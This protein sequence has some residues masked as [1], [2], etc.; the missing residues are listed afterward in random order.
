MAKF[1]LPLHVALPLYEAFSKARAG[2]VL[3]LQEIGETVQA[4]F[5]ALDQVCS[6]V[7]PWT[8]GKT[9]SGV[10]NLVMA[11]PGWKVS[12]K[13]ASDTGNPETALIDRDQDQTF[14]LDGDHRDAF[15]E[16]RH[17]GMRQLLHTY[18]ALAP[19]HA[20]EFTSPL[21]RTYFARYGVQ[22]D[23]ASEIVVHVYSEQLRHRRFDL[24]SISLHK[25]ESLAISIASCGKVEVPLRV[26]TIRGQ[27]GRYRVVD[28]DLRLSAIRR[29]KMDGVLDDSFTVPV[30][31]V[32]DSEDPAFVNA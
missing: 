28:G 3:T 12:Y 8:E 29:C 6:T 16:A 20:S 25:V 1:D 4:V 11:G 21:D 23:P 10:G 7:E 30:V 9:T 2:Q 22:L 32:G 13:I 5:P 18:L 14:V 15:A 19:E 17:G 31:V 26:V 24:S 27:P